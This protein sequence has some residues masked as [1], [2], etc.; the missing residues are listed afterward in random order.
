MLCGVKLKNS[1]CVQNSPTTGE[2]S[3]VFGPKK[4]RPKYDDYLTTVL[5][6]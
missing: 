3:R 4:Y 2:I 5:A 6:K 1:G